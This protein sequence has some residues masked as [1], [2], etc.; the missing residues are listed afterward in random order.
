[1]VFFGIPKQGN[2]GAF[3]AS[4]LCQQMATPEQKGQ[5]LPYVLLRTVASQMCGKPSGHWSHDHQTLRLLPGLM[6][7]LLKCTFDFSSHCFCSSSASM[8]R[9]GPSSSCCCVGDCCLRLPSLLLLMSET[10][11]ASQHACVKSQ[12]ASRV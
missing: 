9:M 11:S 12:Q 10:V 7:M 4:V 1:M 6:R 5:P 2:S 3:L 8:L